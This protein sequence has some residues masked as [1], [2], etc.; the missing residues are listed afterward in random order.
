MSKRSLFWSTASGKLG[1]IVLRTVR[2]ES[3]AAKYQ[4]KVLNPRSYS[5]M[6]IRAEFA[7]AVKFFRHARDNFFK[8]AFEDKKRNESDY[9]AFM[10][11]NARR[12]CIITK[13]L[14]DRYSY[15]A[16]GNRW[17]LANGSLPSL[18][19][20]WMS[21][22]N[23]KAYINVNGV[24]TTDKET[25][26]NFSKKIIDMYGLQNGDFI[27]FVFVVTQYGPGAGPTL[28]ETI[29]PKWYISQIE[30]DE[31]STKTFEDYGLLATWE[32]EDGYISFEK[33]NEYGDDRAAGFAAI[34]S[35]VMKDK[36]LV[37][38][39]EL[40]GNAIYNTIVN[41]YSE[42]AT[43][44]LNL[45][46]WGATEDAILKGSIAN[47][48]N[49]KTL[50]INEPGLI[51]QIPVVPGP[52]DNTTDTGSGADDDTGTSSAGKKSTKSSK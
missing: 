31:T 29:Q 14:S 22:G 44:Q 43:I 21:N 47:K 2:G 6:I 34:A 16:F 46:S 26:G 15:P 30:L 28:D 18:E 48:I 12:G 35:R 19:Y 1:D 37:S 45:K 10:R 23:V 32:E 42:D 17:L 38:S 9:N 27:T 49:N 5:Q 25:I 41:N 40:I 52:D 20:G 7:T 50:R 11:Y 33:P 4:P 36:T 24:S 13:Y 3:I 8:F 51:N 39:S